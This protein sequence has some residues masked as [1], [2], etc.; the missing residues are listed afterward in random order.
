ML[1]KSYCGGR[2]ISQ[3]IPREIFD[4]VEADPIDGARE[5]LGGSE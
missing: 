5:L 4:A 3:P 2:C 1:S